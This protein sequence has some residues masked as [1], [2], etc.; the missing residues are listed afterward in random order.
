[1]VTEKYILKL[2]GT[3][4]FD[5]KKKKAYLHLSSIKKN[6]DEVTIHI[7]FSSKVGVTG[8]SIQP[9]FKKTHVSTGTKR[10][11]THS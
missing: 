5:T 4:L 10:T 9:Q 2:C 8:K 3:F 11:Q 7:F 6:L 1:M